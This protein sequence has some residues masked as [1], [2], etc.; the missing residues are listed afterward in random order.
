MWRK[1][2]Q[3]LVIFAI[4]AVFSG[5]APMN[6]VEAAEIENCH[7]LT[8]EWFGNR[9]MT[10]G[11][12]EEN[13]DIAL[14]N[15]ISGYFDEREM[16]CA[17]ITLMTVGED[18][19]KSGTVQE[20]ML[21]RNIKIAELQ[22]RASIQI[23][24]A[25]VTTLYS[26]EDIIVNDD[27]TITMYVYEWTFFDYDDLSDSKFGTDV[28]G[29]GTYHKITLRE[30]E[31]EYQ[32]VLDEYDESM[33][34]D[35]CTI[36]EETEAE[37]KQME[38]VPA[39]IDV[40]I[41][42]ETEAEQPLY[43]SALGFY[44]A[45]NADAAVAYA[46]KYV[47]HGATGGK[48]YENYYNEGHANFNSIGGDCAN[49]T[50]QCISAGGMP[51]VKCNQYGS[52]GWFYVNSTDRSGT[53]TKATMLA[54]WM[55][56]NR[57][58]RVTPSNTTI[59]KGSPVFY[60][61]SKS[62]NDGHA[63]ICVGLNSA[64]TPII[65]SHNDDL[66]HGLWTY[67]KKATS[68]VQLTPTNPALAQP[69]KKSFDTAE[70]GVNKI[71]VTGWVFDPDDTSKS[72]EIQVYINDSLTGKL[73]ADVYR[74]DVNEKYGCGNY[75]GFKGDISFKPSGTGEHKIDLYA[76][77][78]D[79][80]RA[81]LGSRTVMVTAGIVAY[82][83]RVS[84][85]V[86]SVMVSGWAY[87]PDAATQPLT[88]EIYVDGSYVESFEADELREDLDEAYGCGKNHGYSHTAAY[89]VSKVGTHKV[90]VYAVKGTEKLKV[91]SKTVTIVPSESKT[92]V[93]EGTYG[94]NRY[95]VIDCA[96]T[97]IE[98]K[99][100]CEDAG[101]HLVTITSAA[102]QSFVEGLLKNGGSKKQY[103][104]GATQENGRCSWITEETSNYVNWD[105]NEPNGAVVNGE[106]ETYVQLLNVSNPRVGS[107]QRFKWND[108]VEDNN[109]PNEEDYFAIQHVGYIC[110]IEDGAKEPEV[111]P[112]PDPNPGDGG[113]PDLG[114]GED[115]GDNPVVDP[116]G[117]QIVIDSK[118]AF[119]GDFVG[120]NIALKNNPGIA[121]MKLKVTYGADL[122]LKEIVY[123]D[124]LGGMSQQPQKMDS[125][126]VLNW[127]NGIANT[128]G[129]L[130]YATLKF[131]ISEDAEAGSSTK[132]SVT[133]DPED[134]YNL[135]ETNVA[136]GIVEG[137]VEVSA[138]IPGDI[139]GDG[140]VNNKDLT[141]LFQYHSDWDVKVEEEALDVNGDGSLN[142]KDL[143]RLFQYLSDWD[144]TIH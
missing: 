93:T 118:T 32:I 23:T 49:Y 136:F 81:H 7:T 11:L 133:Y 117:P 141:R 113:E 128:E 99:Q 111:D 63:T 16:S 64:G 129:D 139:N 101:G 84:G 137:T 142:N 5:I 60:W 13:T 110:E 125:P 120:V 138:Y 29:F 115:P 53:W 39:E 2:R 134:V 79:G 19:T 92:V 82:S 114:E 116:N 59:Y 26:D 104:I 77:G 87:H 17:G 20:E 6:D 37:L 42:E 22:E 74:A 62:G 52:T 95:Q 46:D 119:A 9:V 88:M 132:I 127:F 112:T 3:V 75:H 10:L 97:W 38:T 58:V 14:K 70:G 108:A 31:G 140:V 41:Q 144:V 85:R 43:A 122:L 1:L 47:Y 94:D 4:S 109:F 15:V 21:H 12:E 33:L 72:L 73:T 18:D 121:S 80:E 131:Q 126:V 100:Y 30:T 68:T 25:E 45:Y 48:N 130:V 55:G 67:Y 103:W 135:A 66:Y 57:G 54:T 123:N 96:A 107:S 50:S 102:E 51:Q 61:N 105:S 36:T 76:I 27:G 89:Q 40:Q 69:P 91:T 28:S 8:N 44:E 24:D 56:N 90:E 83:D 34:L 78:T 65:N 143:T 106:K 124:A 35:I 98:A 71:S 86:D